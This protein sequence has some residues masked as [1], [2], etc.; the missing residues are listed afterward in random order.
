MCL[1]IDTKIDLS[2]DN[3]GRIYGYKEFD[4]EILKN[5]KIRLHSPYIDEGKR[6][7]SYIISE[8]EDFCDISMSNIIISPISCYE[9]EVYFFNKF[10][11]G[12]SR[13]NTL[14]IKNLGIHM[15]Y[16]IQDNRK[17]FPWFRTSHIETHT[18][19]INLNQGKLDI[20]SIVLPVYTDVNDI[21]LLSNKDIISENLIIPNE[22]D[23]QEYI[24]THF[25]MRTQKIL[26]KNYNLII[27]LIKIDYA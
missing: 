21:Q 2:P 1:S 19:L 18:S 17:C 26:E 12:W 8:E 11:N 5:N 20:N 15:R 10:N 7:K 3:L 24:S 25:G 23:F 6:N 9:Q 27:P 16:K 4:I 13:N 14:R 22:L